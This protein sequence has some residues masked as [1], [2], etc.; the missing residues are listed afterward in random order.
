MAA[1]CSRSACSRPGRRNLRAARRQRCPCSAKS[2]SRSEASVSIFRPIIEVDCCENFSTRLRSLACE[3]GAAQT[4]I[5]G[6]MGARRILGAE[7]DGRIR[8]L[9]VHHLVV[10]GFVPLQAPD[11]PTVLRIG[12]DGTDLI[13]LD[14]GL[15]GI[16]GF[17]IMRTLRREARETPVIILTA[18][19]GEID[20]VLGLELGADD[21]IAKPFSPRELVARVR[22]VLRRIEA[23]RDSG[24]RVLRFGRLEI[25]EAAREARID[26]V[27]IGLKRREYQLLCALAENV[28]IAMSREGL[29]RRIWGYDFGGD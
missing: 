11:G 9:L 8:E 3:R 15:P 20:R 29:L 5:G 23:G 27:D 1:T 7:D 13:V 28:G 25:H 2:P 16:D 22:A 12:R 4:G 18:R 19:A 10:G 6:H 14:V 17:E 21:Y 26:G 24:P